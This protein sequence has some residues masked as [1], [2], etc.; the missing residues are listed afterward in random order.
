V[1]P[2]GG[3]RYS[4]TCG[5]TGGTRSFAPESRSVSG[6]AQ[7]EIWD[8]GRQTRSFMY[9][10]DCVCGTRRLMGSDV[11]EPNLGSDEVVTVDQL[12]GMI[13][14]I[15]GIKVARRYNHEAFHGVRGRSSDNTIIRDQLGWA[16]STGLH[17]GLARTY[18]WVHDQVATLIGIH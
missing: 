12:V 9:I 17:D 10:D 11:R 4:G 8:D 6:A 7:I 2:V 5:E 18:A 16:R 14:E 1:T 15:V 3:S 13:E